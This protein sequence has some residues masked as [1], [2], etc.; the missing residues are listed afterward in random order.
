MNKEIVKEVIKEM[1][2]NGEIKVDVQ[3]DV[4][5]SFID[6]EGRINCDGGDFVTDIEIY[7]ELEVGEQV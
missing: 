3:L 1:I 5:K 6:S 4:F 7:V 2:N